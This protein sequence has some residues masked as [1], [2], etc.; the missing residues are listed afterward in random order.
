MGQSEVLSGRSVW[1]QHLLR[2]CS[3]TQ[4]GIWQQ[5]VRDTGVEGSPPLGGGLSAML[6]HLPEP[7]VPC[8]GKRE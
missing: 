6:L 2:L 5:F 3:P 1:R 4:V 7:Q 8:L